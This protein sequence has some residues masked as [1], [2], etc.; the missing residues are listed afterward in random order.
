MTDFIV[1]NMSEF[2]VTCHTETCENAEIVIR[3]TAFTDN[4]FIMCGPCSIQIEDVTLV[5]NN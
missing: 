5:A 3:V 2:D 4:T 1:P